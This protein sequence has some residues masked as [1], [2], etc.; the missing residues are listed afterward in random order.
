MSAEILNVFH[1]F[2]I[3]SLIFFSVFFLLC[4]VCFFLRLV[5]WCPWLFKPFN[6]STEANRR[7]RFGVEQTEDGEHSRGWPD[8]GISSRGDVDVS[9]NRGIPKSS[10]LIGFSIINHPFWGTPIFGNTHVHSTVRV[11]TVFFCQIIGEIHALCL[12]RGALGIP[13]RI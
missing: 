3:F 5:V 13:C 6:R 11:L 2:S 9:K 4:F 10:I 8:F 1:D 7:E 12:P